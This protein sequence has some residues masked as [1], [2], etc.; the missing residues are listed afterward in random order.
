MSRLDLDAIERNAK[1]LAQRLGPASFP[2]GVVALCGEIRRL[3]TSLARCVNQAP[4]DAKRAHSSPQCL[5][6]WCEAH[7]LLSEVS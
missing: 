6:R 7:R 5:C 1:P 4:H 2:A 3:R